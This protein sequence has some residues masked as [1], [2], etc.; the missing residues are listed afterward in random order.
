MIEKK[1]KNCKHFG[2][3]LDMNLDAYCWSGLMVTSKENS[4]IV[5]EPKEE[6]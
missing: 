5:F 3:N 2:V 4:C 6:E 1:C